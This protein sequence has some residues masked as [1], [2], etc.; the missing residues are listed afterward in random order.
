[1]KNRNLIIK[2]LGLNMDAE[3]VIPT[4]NTFDD[5]TDFNVSWGGPNSS[6][7]ELGK[8]V[9]YIYLNP[10]DN[11]ENEDLPETESLPIKEGN[12]YT[13]IKDVIMD[14][15]EISNYKGKTYQSHKDGYIDDEDIEDPYRHIWSSVEDTWDYFRP[16]TEE[17]IAKA[18]AERGTLNKALDFIVEREKD[19]DYICE[20]MSEFADEWDYCENNCQNLQKECVLRYLKRKK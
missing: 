20:R 14:T 5:T 13:C 8:D 9:E 7:G 18:E 12:W 2:L 17:E 11:V 15:G 4:G 1:M 10:S 16:A 6:D 3:V 19:D